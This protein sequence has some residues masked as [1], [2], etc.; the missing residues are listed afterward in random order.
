MNQN[1]GSALYSLTFE[2]LEHLRTLSKHDPQKVWDSTLEELTSGA[3]NHVV[4]TSWNLEVFPELKKASGKS[5]FDI[6]NS[7]L[8]YKALNKLSPLQAADERFWVSLTLGRYKEY[9]LS[10]W[11]KASNVSLENHVANHIF[12]TTSR[13]RFRDQA[14]ARLWWIGRFIDRNLNESSNQAYSVLLDLDTDIINSYLG[15]PNLVSLP[16]IAKAVVDVTYEAF[17]ANGHRDVYIRRTY[18][19]FIMA[20][21]LENGRQLISHKSVEEMTRQVRE[22]FESFFPGTLK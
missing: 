4:A 10:R 12:G 7:K 6:E 18:R 2:G 8:I 22:L 3:E 9:V 13:S 20:I 21:D 5:N 1:N 15:R 16:G 19:D 11:V 17:F 14:L